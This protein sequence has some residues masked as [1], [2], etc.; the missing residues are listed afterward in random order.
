[1]QRYITTISDDPDG[2]LSF[3]P[4]TGCVIAAITAVPNN[5]EDAVGEDVVADVA[6]G[7]GLP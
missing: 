5:A 3:W 2:S 4:A 1:M 7:A 6:C